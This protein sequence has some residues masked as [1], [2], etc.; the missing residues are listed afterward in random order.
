M[1]RLSLKFTCTDVDQRGNV[2]HYFR[3]NG[4]KIRLP[5]AVGS[6]EFMSAYQAAL[7]GL[8]EGATEPKHVPKESF[9]YLCRS[10]FVSTEFSLLDRSTQSWRRS[11]LNR[12]CK[13][14]GSAQFKRIE[15]Q[16]VRKFVADLGEKPAAARNRLKALKA[17]FAWA[18]DYGL[19]K[20]NPTRDVRAPRYKSK[21]HHA[22]TVEEQKQFE[23]FY[24]VGTKARLAYELLLFSA[25]RR[26]DVVRFGPQNIKAGRFEYQQAKNEDRNPIRVSLPFDDG[27]AS[28]IG[29][30]PCGDMLFLMTEYGQS[31][32]ANGFGN[33]F[34]S[35]CDAAGLRH[36]RAHGLRKASAIR[37]I[38][39]GATPDEVMAVTGHTSYAQFLRYI[40]DADKRRL[41][42]QAFAKLTKIRTGQPAK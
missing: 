20:D 36:C 33:K 25:C 14:Y 42:N 39:A 2:R 35:W 18:I 26:E 11:H 3:R 12:I 7:E 38:E 10:Y 17:L 5:G 23:D 37:L 4:K 27:L 9:E 22:W 16:H 40:E 32:S 21:G 31:F 6:T 28:V 13:D 8:R 19:V 15:G 1:T 41:A 34:R 29:A 30:T 24:Q